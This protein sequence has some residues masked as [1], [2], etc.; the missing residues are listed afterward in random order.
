MNKYICQYNTENCTFGIKGWT[1]MENQTD[2]SKA[3]LRRAKGWLNRQMNWSQGLQLRIVEVTET[4]VF[5][6]TIS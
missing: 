3:S 4:A 6:Q 5:N 2:K 1:P